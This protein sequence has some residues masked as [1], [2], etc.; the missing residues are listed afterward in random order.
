MFMIS[1]IKIYSYQKANQVAVFW[2]QS[3]YK[4]CLRKF[5]KM[6]LNIVVLSQWLFLDPKNLLNFF[7]SNYVNS[8]KCK[9]RENVVNEWSHQGTLGHW[10]ACWPLVNVQNP[11]QLQR[12]HCFSVIWKSF[13]FAF[14]TTKITHTNNREK[15]LLFRDILENITR[16]NKK[17]W[18]KKHNPQCPSGT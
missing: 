5:Y 12:T 11:L 1:S 14:S 2:E 6:V 7:L 8:L 16:M 3:N 4:I 17:I 9:K 13:A 10:S 15:N 18:H